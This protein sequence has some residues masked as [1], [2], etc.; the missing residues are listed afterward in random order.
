MFIKNYKIPTK[1]KEENYHLVPSYMD[2][3]V[4]SFSEFSDDYFSMYYYYSISQ[5]G[6]W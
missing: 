4:E 6:S 5:L 1:Y 3:H 2:I